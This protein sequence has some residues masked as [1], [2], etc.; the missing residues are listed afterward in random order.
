M[1]VYLFQGRGEQKVF[2]LSRDNTVASELAA[3]QS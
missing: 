1:I 2:H 3:I